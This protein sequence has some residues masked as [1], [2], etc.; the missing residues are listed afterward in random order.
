MP[1]QRLSSRGRRALAVL[2]GVTALSAP[3]AAEAHRSWLVPANTNFSGDD[4][5]VAVDA[6][7]SNELFYADH[8]PMSLDNVTAIA[9]DGTKLPIENGA[10]G[11]YR[12]TFDVHLSQPGTTRIFVLNN[13]VG[14]TYVVDG[15]TYRVGGRRGGMAA[16]PGAAPQGPGSA[17][18]QG[19][20]RR[21]QQGVADPS[22]IP[23]AAT[24]IKLVQSTSRN[25]TFVTRGAPTP[26]KPTGV[27]LELADTGVHPTDLVADEP[28]T[29]K[30]LMDGKP[31][32][33]V[34]VTVV[35]ADQR[36]AA[37]IPADIKVTT[38]AEGAFTVKWP[39][40]GFYWLNAT[41]EGG[42][43]SIPHATRRASYTATLEVQKP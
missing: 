16:G 25:E 30:L 28:A 12:S 41:A 15:Q 3:L 4:P 37:S 10:K 35:A 17:G 26:L 9:P 7:V 36:F 34:E 24:D 32:A 38:D 43:G 31:A 5:W 6:A 42:P 33:G 27:G 40:A 39:T 13:N 2:A 21:A 23:A 18:P 8:R 11:Q 1:S 14:G 20:G 19:G 29:F 22:Q